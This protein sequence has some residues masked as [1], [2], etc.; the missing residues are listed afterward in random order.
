MQ[1][2]NLKLSMRICVAPTKPS[3]VALATPDIAP[4]KPSRVALA[5]PHIA[6]TKPS[7]V[8]LATPDIAPTKPSR[9]ALATPHLLHAACGHYWFQWGQTVYAKGL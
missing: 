4:T 6:P 1:V 5:T 9:V 3:R 7:R 2:F 8:A